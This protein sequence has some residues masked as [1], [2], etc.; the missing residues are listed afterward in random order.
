MA[1]HS[2][3][4]GGSI[5]SRRLHCPASF[6]EQLRA[7][8]G[9][10]S[11]YAEEGTHR[12]NAMAYWLANPDISLANLNIDGRAMTHEDVAALELAEDAWACEREHIE[13]ER[14]Q[15]GPLLGREQVAEM[16]G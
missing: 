9:T 11:V 8:P 5:A 2:T 10:T 6:R 3:L 15:A 4:L 13:V 16:M 7:P 12:H 1:T 14:I